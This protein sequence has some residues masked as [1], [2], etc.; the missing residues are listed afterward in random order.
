VDFLKNI[1]KNKLK[2]FLSSKDI[3]LEV[4]YPFLMCFFGTKFCIMIFFIT[5]ENLCF[6]QILVYFNEKYKNQPLFFPFFFV[7]IQ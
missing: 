1:L 4:Q 6:K 5:L 3:F 7:S 2:R